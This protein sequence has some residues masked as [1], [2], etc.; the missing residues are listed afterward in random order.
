MHKKNIL[1][2]RRGPNKRSCLNKSDRNS[3][4]TFSAVS[5]YEDSSSN[6]ISETTIAQNSTLLISSKAV[7]AD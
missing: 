4:V 6:Y 3:Q 2:R 7:E 1:K 5:N